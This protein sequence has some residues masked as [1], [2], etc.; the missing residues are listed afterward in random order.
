MEKSNKE[1]IKFIITV[2][3]LIVGIIVVGILII[4][5]KKNSCIKVS[6]NTQT[7][8]KINAVE[9]KKDESI[10]LPTVTRDGYD[11]IG[12]YLDDKLIDDNYKY[13]KS[14]T[15]TAK[16]EAKS[17]TVSF[18][19]NGGTTVNS[20]KV[21]YNDKLVLPSAPTKDGYIFLS[22]ECNG[23]EYKGGET[24][25]T[26]LIL[27][28]KWKEDET[29]KN[30]FT[31]SFDSNGGSAVN[32][33]KVT[34]GGA[35]PTLPIPTKTGSAFYGWRN[36]NNVVVTSG[37]VL[38][39]EDITL[40]AIWR[41]GT[42]VQP[43]TSGTRIIKFNTNGGN[44]ITARRMSCSVQTSLP[45]PTKTGYVFVGW[46]DSNGNRVTNTASLPCSAVTL[47]ARW[48]STA[49]TI[50]PT[51]G[52]N[53]TNKTFTI[54]FDSNGGSSVNQ[55]IVQCGQP[56]PSLPRPTKANSTFTIWLNK[57][58]KQPLN[59]GARLTTCED[60]EAIANWV[61]VRTK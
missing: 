7:E 39:C 47:T 46:F 36:A 56:L 8:T 54:T 18:E 20:I 16:W 48:S 61:T 59:A 57:K 17:F 22:W 24:I 4:N 42:V 43:T 31:V 3:C 26:D 41:S 49:G 11:F 6:F 30:T 5:T 55:M 28:A 38:D 37:K 23:K 21:K 44:N 50:T 25:T 35:L 15:L 14:V 27:T 58:T 29:A 19:T 53:S 1:N 12:W 60:I 10:E 45:T 13:T 9:V 51:P 32:S 2:V 33:I 34:C 52:G 40:I